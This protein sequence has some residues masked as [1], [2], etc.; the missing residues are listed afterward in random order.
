MLLWRDLKLSEKLG[1]KVRKKYEVICGFKRKEGK[2][3]KKRIKRSNGLNELEIGVLLNV[4]L[5]QNSVT[6]EITT[7]KTDLLLHVYR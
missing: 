3:K 6:T 4:L 1:F 2:K 5:E 7:V